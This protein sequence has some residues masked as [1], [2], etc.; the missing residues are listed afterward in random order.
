MTFRELA[1]QI[2]LSSPSITERVLKLQDAGAIQGYTV[3]VT[4]KV[5][6]LGISA[7]LRMHAIPGQLSRLAQMLVDTPE[8]V[9]ADRVTGQDCFLAKV[10][11][12]DLDQLEMVVDRFAQFASTDTA[13]IQSSPVPRRL[14][15]L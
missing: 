1:T 9:E 2:G 3:S 14:P 6:G 11:V 15:N 7:H 5:F 12:R 10:V 8:I 13:I 4:P